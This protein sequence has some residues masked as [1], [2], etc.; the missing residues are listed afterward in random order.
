MISSTKAVRP[1]LFSV[2]VAAVTQ[3]LAYTENVNGIEWTYH[4]EN[5]AAIV[6][7][8]EL[9]NDGFGDYYAAVSAVPE[10]TSGAVK[11]PT[12]LGGCPVRGIGE[13]AFDDCALIT[14]ITIPNGVTEIGDFAFAWCEKL[15]KVVIPASVTGIGENA[16]TECVSLTSISLDSGNKS[17]VYSGSM[18]LSKNKK[19]LFTVSRAAKTLAIPNGVATLPQGLMAGCRKLT[20]VTLPASVV[21]TADGWADAFGY[22]T[23]TSLKTI[24]VDP[25]N[26]AVKSVNNLL[27]DKE[28]NSI[29]Y[30]PAGL[31]AI[32]IPA[33]VRDVDLYTAAK[34]T[35]VTVDSKNPYFK[36]SGGCVLSKDGKTFLY[37][38]PA[39]KAVT[40]P[41]GVKTI[42]SW[43]FTDGRAESVTIPATVTQIGDEENGCASSAR[44]FSNKTKSI[45]FLG[46]PPV[47]LWKSPL[48]DYTGE[49]RARTITA[50]HTGVCAVSDEVDIPC[51]LAYYLGKLNTLVGSAERMID[52]RIVFRRVGYDRPVLHFVSS[53]EI[54]ALRLADSS[55]K[56]CFF[57]VFKSLSCRNRNLHYKLVYV[58]RSVKIYLP[59][60]ILELR[61]CVSMRAGDNDR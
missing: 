40:V 26:P 50:Y 28:D 3:V 34:C 32:T 59:R 48:S 5:G 35:K 31:T 46:N 8:R 9:R 20:S 17:F 13:S 49:I 60:A 12:R 43:S 36:S 21:E 57:E 19:R 54:N 53:Y 58:R 45:T 41:S 27:I 29:A 33:S 61:S 39:L 23:C 38:P 14:S 24:T 55:K 44:V 52:I 7:D 2:L 10:D 4:V 16:F 1:A 6:G 51:A 30:A 56:F 42:A 15:A 22:D 47:E 37:A 25:K 11:V 18:L